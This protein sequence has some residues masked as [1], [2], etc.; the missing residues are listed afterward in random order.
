MD[1]IS[2]NVINNSGLDLPQYQTNGAVALDLQSA[3]RESIVIPS[4]RSAL[5][6]TGLRI[7][8]PKGFEF[9]IRSRSGLAL[10]N[11]IAVLN[12]PGT[13]DSDYRGDVGVIL[14]NHGMSK[15][16]VE[17]GDRIAQGVFSRVGYID[18]KEVDSL[19]DT[20]RGE[21]GFGHTGK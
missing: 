15:F 6:P 14:I 16:I 7:A 5:I 9:Q 19:D 18:W 12:S 1:V 11:E 3:S 20:E 8:I 17:Y 13:I 21:E 2:I 4:F 10:K